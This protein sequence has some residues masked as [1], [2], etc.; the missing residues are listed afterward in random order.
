MLPLKGIEPLSRHP[1][2]SRRAVLFSRHLIGEPAKVLVGVCK[3]VVDDLSKEVDRGLV[4]SGVEDADV[5]SLVVCCH[6]SGEVTRSSSGDRKARGEI[7]GL[8]TDELASTYL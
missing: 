1:R 8:M 4:D 7:A 6:Q 5:E 3:R 2:N